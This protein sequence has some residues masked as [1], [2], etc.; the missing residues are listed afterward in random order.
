M[1]L[2]TGLSW[3]IVYDFLFWDFAEGLS[4]YHEVNDDFAEVSDLNPYVPKER[5]A[6]LPPNDHYFFWIYPCQEELHGKSRSKGVG[7]YLFVL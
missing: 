6:R 2:G 1:I 4:G 7:T 3:S 5:I